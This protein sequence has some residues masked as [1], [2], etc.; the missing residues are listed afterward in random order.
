MY[1]Y[2]SIFTLCTHNKLSL[3]SVCGVT[4]LRDIVLVPKTNDPDVDLFTHTWPTLI[5]TWCKFM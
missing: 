3:Q 4:F 2:T 1:S 5:G